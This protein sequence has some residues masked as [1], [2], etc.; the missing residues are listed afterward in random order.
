[1]SSLDGV[2]AQLDQLQAS[3]EWTNA[4]AQVADAEIA[5]ADSKVRLASGASKLAE[6]MTII[7]L[8][9]LQLPDRCDTFLYLTSAAIALGQ[10]LL[11]TS[12]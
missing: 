10:W 2:C 11:S 12:A 8:V 9:F 1:M 3:K 7:C 4:F 5:L 6:P